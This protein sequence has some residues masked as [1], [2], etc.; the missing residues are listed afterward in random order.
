M[1]LRLLSILIFSLFILLPQISGA[2]TT[3]NLSLPGNYLGLVGYWTFDGGDINWDSNT[4][5][6]KSGSGNDGIMSNIVASSSQVIGKVGQ[7]IQFDGEDDDI[8]FTGPA[9]TNTHTISFWIYPQ[10]SQP[11]AY[12]TIITRSTLSPY[13][14]LMYTGSDSKITYYY[15]ADHKNNTA[16]PLNTW[17]H[18]VASVSNGSLTFYLN[19][20]ADGTASGVPAWTVQDMATNVWNEDLK[21]RLD[22]VRVYSRALSAKEVNQLYKR[23]QVKLNTSPVDLLTNGLVG[24]WT[25]DG[26]DI[27]WDTNTV[28][29]RSGNGNTGSILNV[30]TSS[31]QVIGKV[32]QAIS[33]LPNGADA[34]NTGNW[35]EVDSGPLS[36]S[37]WAKHISFS[38]FT[39]LV[40][41][42]TNTGWLLFIQAS[43]GKLRF[44]VQFD[45]GSDLIAESDNT[46]SLNEWNHYVLTWDGSGSSSGVEMYIDGAEFP[47]TGITEGMGDYLVPDEDL[48]IG[49]NIILNGNLDMQGFVDDVRIYN[50]VLNTQE[51][52]ALY[53][54]GR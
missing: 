23:G 53:N 13:P 37:M 11:A 46:I 3:F 4:L 7:G 54:V 42:G 34:V 36:I 33:F 26:K 2:D 47:F 5:I 24:Y 52:K 9:L 41:H 51:V 18:I 31:G 8:T 40:S 30:A 6:D 38:L 12:S 35:D 21:A 45:G 29:D 1:K 44:Q 27:D 16:L 32:G 25:F 10:S 17:S 43:S 22:E 20:S 14:G 50:R 15:S 28:T 39:D 49:G 19:G 48:M